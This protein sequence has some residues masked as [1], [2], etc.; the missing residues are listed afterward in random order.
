M[1]EIYRASVPIILMEIAVI[2]FI[3]LFPPLAIWLPT[4]M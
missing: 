4:R 3:M 1:G 2:V